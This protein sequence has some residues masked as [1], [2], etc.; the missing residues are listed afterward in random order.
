MSEVAQGVRYV[1][2][3]LAPGEAYDIQPQTLKAPV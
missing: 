2:G 1:Y 3:L